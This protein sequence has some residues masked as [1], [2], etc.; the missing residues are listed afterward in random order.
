MCG[1]ALWIENGAIA[2]DG[3]PSDAARLYLG[4]QS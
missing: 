2:F 1:R 4:T 3:D